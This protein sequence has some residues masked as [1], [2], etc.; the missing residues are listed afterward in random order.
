MSS[1]RAT[2]ECP[3]LAE[4]MREFAPELIAGVAKWRKLWSGIPRNAGA[5]A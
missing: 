3:S 2:V 5:L 1:I 4:T